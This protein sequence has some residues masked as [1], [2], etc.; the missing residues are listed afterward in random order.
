MISY[1]PIVTCEFLNVTNGSPVYSES[2][3]SEN[4]FAVGTTVFFICNDNHY[5]SGV[6]KL[7]CKKSGN[8][9]HVT[10]VCKSNGNNIF[11]I[12]LPNNRF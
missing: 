2:S 9:N 4:G 1:S 12:H 6:G 5:L 11:F 3:L 8:W 10:P 7:T